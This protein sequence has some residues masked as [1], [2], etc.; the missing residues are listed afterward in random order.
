VT[1]YDVTPG[2]PL[3]GVPEDVLLTAR[4]ALGAFDE[5]DD[6][7]DNVVCEVGDA[8][9]ANLATRGY[10]TWSS[11]VPDRESLIL[12]LMVCQH[13]WEEGDVDGSPSLLEHLVDDMVLPLLRNVA[14][15]TETTTVALPD[16]EGASP[17]R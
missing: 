17:T 16:D 12:A 2:H 14:S 7:D 9:V 4:E 3:A 10:V 15:L 8:V 13:E 6:W 1:R 5:V 11:R